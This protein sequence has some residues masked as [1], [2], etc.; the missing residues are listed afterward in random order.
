MAWELFSGEGQKN[1]QAIAVTISGGKLFYFNRFAAEKY[2]NGS[3]NKRLQ[4]YFDK[5]LKKI[6][7]KPS[8]DA[9]YKIA[10]VGG[11]GFSISSKIFIE[12]LKQAK[13]P[14]KNKVKYY[15]EWD[16]ENQMFVFKL[17]QGL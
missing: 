14:V 7:F 1:E 12:H 17:E 4:C 5:R 3:K 11:G 9:G 8:E 16:N 13:M 15:G 10:S 6:A 2:L